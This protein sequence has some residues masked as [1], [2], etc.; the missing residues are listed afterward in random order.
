MATSMDDVLGDKVPE[1]VEAQ[2]EPVEVETVSSTREA[3]REVEQRARDEQGKFLPKEKEE[4]KVEAKVEAPKE[5]KK[6]PPK[7]DFSEK[8][9]A[10]LRAAEAERQKRQQLESELKALK[11]ERAKEPKKPFWDDPEGAVA[12][13][14]KRIEQSEQNLRQEA[15]RSHLRTTEALARSRYSDFDEKIALLEEMVQSIPGLQQQWLAAVDPADFAYKTAK[16][17]KDL[18]DAGGLDA[19]RAKMETEIRAKIEKELKER[20]EQLRAERAK[21][22]PSL[23][24]TR[25][26]APAKQVWSGPT[27]FDTIIRG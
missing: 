7:Q 19:Y 27:P 10:F 21:L 20:E 1:K 11:E 3:H 23:T 15:M 14:N 6:E 9:R 5:E 16:N 13:I 22:P 24:D 8:E 26:T 12:E 4:P 2:V 17:K 25:S 18:D